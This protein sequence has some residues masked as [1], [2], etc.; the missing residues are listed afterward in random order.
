MTVETL[1]TTTEPL[2]DYNRDIQV[3]GL[4]FSMRG[5]KLPMGYELT[6]HI[7]APHWENEKD[8]VSGTAEETHSFRNNDGEIAF[9]RL[10][11]PMDKVYDKTL[12][13]FA[14]R[15]KI[16]RDGDYYSQAMNLNTVLIDELFR[17]ASQ[18]GWKIKTDEFLDDAAQRWLRR[19][20][21]YKEKLTKLSKPNLDI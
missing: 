21:E 8:S 16:L 11:N 1:P 2:G 5:H 9:L 20:G 17:I 6:L 15:T 19:N 4:T 14:D 13:N 3:R 18:E 10:S 12:R 7:P